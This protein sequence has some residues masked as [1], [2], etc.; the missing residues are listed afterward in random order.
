MA[1]NS[2]RTWPTRTRSPLRTLMLASWAATSGATRISVTRT[3]PT[4]GVSS[5]VRNSSYPRAPAATSTRAIA[6]MPARFLAMRLPPLDEECGHHRQHEI[7][8]GE[9]PKAPPVARD[10][11]QARAQ[12][13]DAHEPVDREV[14]REDIADR[15]RPLGDRLARPGKPG[16]E[17]LWQAGAEEDQGRRFRVLEPGTRRL[18]HEARRQEEHQA[19]R[20]QLQRLSES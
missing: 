15:P 9:N 4:M 20:E 18:A 19:Q 10:L 5:V 2:A 13:V 1:D 14:R 3:T 12:L 7:A 17:Q 6:M 16:Q 8:D 11:P